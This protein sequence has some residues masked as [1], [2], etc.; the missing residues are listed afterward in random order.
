MW[1]DGCGDGFEQRRM[2]RTCIKD[3]DESRGEKEES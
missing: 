2:K 3:P 1:H